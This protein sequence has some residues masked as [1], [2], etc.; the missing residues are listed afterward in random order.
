MP[1]NPAFTSTQVTLRLADTKVLVVPAELFYP[2]VEHNVVVD[3][4]QKARFVA[5]LKQM[6]IQQII[7]SGAVC[8][9]LFPGQVVLLAG[10]D[11]AV[12]QA[13]GIVAGHHELHGGEERLDKLGLLVIQVLPD[14]LVHSHLGAL[15]FQH[16]EGN[17]IH[18]EHDIRAL[19]IDL[20]IST[21]DGNF[22]GNGEVV[23]LRML[24]VDQPDGL[25]V[26]PNFRLDLHPVA[27]QLVH[28]LVTIIQALADIVGGLV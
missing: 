25:G 28:R 15:E 24:P 3:Q 19:G 26:F 5:Q 11:S 6:G 18:I 9:F 8:V 16:A 23:V 27:Q 17:A 2:A 20:G 21:F 10:L 1:D 7:G 22:L 13:L 14:A 4:L 12:T